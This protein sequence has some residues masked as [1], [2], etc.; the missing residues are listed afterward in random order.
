[1]QWV[2]EFL[3]GLNSVCSKY[4]INVLIS[5]IP[6][7]AS[8]AFKHQYSDLIQTYLTE[9]LL[10]DG[11]LFANRFYPTITHK[12][13]HVRKLLRSIDRALSNFDFV[14]PQTSLAGS[15]KSSIY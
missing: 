10:E 6:A 7:M 1:M 12:S 11:Y 14:N 5:E 3:N 13:R 15:V 8:Y 4:E 2:Q 9:R